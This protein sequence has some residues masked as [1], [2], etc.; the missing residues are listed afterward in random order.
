MA[1][2]MIVTEQ[3]FAD[4]WAAPAGEMLR[5][6]LVRFQDG[7]KAEVSDLAWNHPEQLPRLAPAAKASADTADMIV[8]LEYEGL[9]AWLQKTP[10][11]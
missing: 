4:W 9:L 5:A 7:C 8:N 1:H 3:E 11:A 10:A 2:P 6:A